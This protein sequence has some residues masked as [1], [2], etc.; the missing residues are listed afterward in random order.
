[1]SQRHQQ[2]DAL[3]ADSPS[4]SVKSRNVLLALH[5]VCDS[6]LNYHLLKWEEYDPPPLASHEHH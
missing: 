2:N 6:R 3:L 5:I 1:M 4:P